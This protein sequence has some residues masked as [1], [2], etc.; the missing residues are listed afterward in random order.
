[1]ATLHRDDVV[2]I[3][4]DIAPRPVIVP[5]S[6]GAGGAPSAGEPTHGWLAVTGVEPSWLLLGAAVVLVAVGV[7]LLRSRRRRR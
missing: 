2:S 6:P 5:P 3:E 1:M 7:A 4:V